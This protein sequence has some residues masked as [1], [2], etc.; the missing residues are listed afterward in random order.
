MRLEVKVAPRAARDA[1]AGWL[2]PALKVRLAAVPERG[3]ANAA[4][5]RLLAEVLELPAARVKLVAGHASARKLID[6]DGL[7]AEEVRRRLDRA[8]AR[9][10]PEARR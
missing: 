2:G 10:A 6:I 5:V 8:L 9:A 7:A 1:L 3:A 4:L